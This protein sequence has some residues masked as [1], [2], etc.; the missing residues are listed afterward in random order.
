MVAVSAVMS[1][2]LDYMHFL[3]SMHGP[4]FSY[5]SNHH[6]SKLGKGEVRYAEHLTG[7]IVIIIIYQKKCCRHLRYGTWHV[8]VVLRLHFVL[9]TSHVTSKIRSCQGEMPCKVLLK[10]S[11]WQVTSL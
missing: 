6:L 10:G 7:Q 3:T 11:M 5:E 2:E 1:P 8:F 9:L 4:G